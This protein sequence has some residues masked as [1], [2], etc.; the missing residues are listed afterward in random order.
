ME[1]YE[2]VRKLYVR[3]EIGHE[4]YESFR[5]ISKELKRAAH[6]AGLGLKIL[7]LDY[8]SDN[9]KGTVLNNGDVSISTNLYIAIKAASKLGKEHSFVVTGVVGLKRPLVAVSGEALEI[10]IDDEM[11][12][13]D[14]ITYRYC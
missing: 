12:D 11:K 7:K 13:E 1:K 4:Y 10:I 5:I 6:N 9:D 8:K 14:I 2:V 3:E